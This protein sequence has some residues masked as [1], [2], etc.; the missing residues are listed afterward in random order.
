MIAGHFCIKWTY[1]K[2]HVEES[3]CWEPLDWLSNIKVNKQRDKY[4]KNFIFWVSARGLKNIPG[5]W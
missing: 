2:L 4:R 5:G 1:G 3:E